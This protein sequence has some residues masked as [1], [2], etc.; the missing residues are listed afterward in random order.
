MWIESLAGW[1][2]KQGSTIFAR[3]ILG[4][5]YYLALVAIESYALQRPVRLSWVSTGIVMGATYFLMWSID[6]EQEQ[7]KNNQ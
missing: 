1:W 4:H 5:F 3:L 2:E 7:E 6:R